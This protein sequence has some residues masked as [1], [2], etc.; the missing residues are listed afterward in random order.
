MNNLDRAIVTNEQAVKSAAADDPNRAL[1]FDN[2][3][4][5]LQNRFNKTGSI[6]DLDRAIAANEQAVKSTSLTAPCISPIWEL[7]CKTDSG[8]QDR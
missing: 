2:L 6:G 1:Y 8:R 4:S 3:G 5:A 7:H